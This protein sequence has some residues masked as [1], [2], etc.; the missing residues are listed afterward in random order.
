MTDQ[1][2][3]IDTGLSVGDLKEELRR[4]IDAYNKEKSDDEPPLRL[5]E[6][7][8]AK[9]PGFTGAEIA[10]FFGGA[11]ASGITY[12]IL[13]YVIIK[14]VLPRINVQFGSNAIKIK[15]DQ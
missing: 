9:S 5:S 4:G 6:L 11:V 2:L 12:D 1:T 10:I 7:T 3:I 13:K 8:I 15:E 14:H